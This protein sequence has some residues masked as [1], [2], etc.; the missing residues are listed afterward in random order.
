[1]TINFTLA[2]K[3]AGLSGMSSGSH[4]LLMKTVMEELASRGHEDLG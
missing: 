4:Y 2:T 3:I 1:V